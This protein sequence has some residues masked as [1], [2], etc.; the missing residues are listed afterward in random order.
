MRSSERQARGST[1]KL[2]K[3]EGIHVSN[4][5]VNIDVKYFGKD[6][7]NSDVCLFKRSGGEKRFELRRN[8]LRPYFYADANLK[9]PATFE[10]LI[11]KRVGGYESIFGKPLQKLELNFITRT[12]YEILRDQCGETF[13][14]DVPFVLRNIFDLNLKYDKAQRKM[15]LDI[16]TDLCNTPESPTKAVTSIACWDSFTRKYYVFAW[17]S[18][19]EKECYSANVK[20]DMGHSVVDAVVEYNIFSDEISMLAKFLDFF[21][22]N[23]PDIVSGWY[24]SGFDVPYLIKR[25][26][27]LGLKPDRLSVAEKVVCFDKGE[28]Q[29]TRWKAKPRFFTKISGVSIVDLRYAFEHLHYR[30]PPNYKLD[31]VSKFIFGESSGK[32]ARLSAA[33]W[34]EKFSEFVKYNI[35]DVALCVE[36]DEKLHLVDY[37][38][39]AQQVVPLPLEKFE[40]E[41]QVVDGYL[42][43]RLKGTKIRMPTKKMFS[44]AEFAALKQFE[45]ARVKE[46]KRGF[47]KNVVVYDFKGMYPSIYRAFNISPETLCSDGDIKIKDDV[48]FTSKKEGIVPRVLTELLEER[49]RIKKLRD[50][51]EKS[52]VEWYAYNEQNGAFKMICNSFFGVFGFLN[53]RLH[54][55]KIAECIT[56]LG[57]EL[58]TFSEKIVEDL[59]YR[60]NFI[61]TDSLHVHFGDEIASEKELLELST[62]V[63]ETVNSKL[64]DFINLYRSDVREN[65]FIELERDKVCKSAYFSG[66]K[67]KYFFLHFDGSYTVKGFELVRRDTPIVV[68]KVL[69]HL[70]L[71][72][73]SG[74]L[75]AADLVKAF[76]QVKSAPLEDVG[77]SKIVNKFFDEYKVNAQHVRA[78][79]WANKNLGEDIRKTDRP[80][81]FYVKKKRPS[82]SDVVAVNDVSKLASLEVDYEVLFEKFV[83]A[84]LK[85]FDDIECVKRTLADY[86]L[87]RNCQST[88]KEFVS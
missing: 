52:S 72:G 22:K 30:Q 78:S 85:Q 84:K 26:E 36:L 49:E 2:E 44:D 45:G 74:A 9:L 40:N 34:K 18:E 83:L 35:N 42:L 7:E 39:N 61:D 57:R 6:K 65:K 58:I 66:K 73:M 64:I 12:Q 11:Y 70:L 21:N 33:D 75:Q 81:L 53:F 1:K 38:L 55:F 77:V 15:F 51:F 88:L 82:D 32:L 20:L 87:V 43:Y 19:Y 10:K 24:V 63:N 8:M 48:R 27:G 69:K 41:S 5:I 37:F 68:K 56:Y 71:S 28:Q 3:F 62:Q 46:P 14:A 16:E 13:E 59:G 86:E 50:S 60:V 25:I 17:H 4:E 23:N 67:K 29:A 47:F 80:M 79:Q 31:T 54:S 76:E